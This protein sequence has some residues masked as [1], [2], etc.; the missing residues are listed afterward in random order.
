VSDIIEGANIVY[1]TVDGVSETEPP[2]P[3]KY[4]AVKALL[5]VAEYNRI[6]GAVVAVE[7]AN[8]M[9]VSFRLADLLNE[10][11]RIGF[12]GWRLFMADGSEYPYSVEN[13]GKLNSNGELVQKAIEEFVS[14]N[15]ILTSKR[16]KS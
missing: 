16:K 4:I 3:E 15:P 1:V 13:I 12:V 14:R 2:K 9:T 8:E 5:S 6:Q 11:M 10:Q 7:K